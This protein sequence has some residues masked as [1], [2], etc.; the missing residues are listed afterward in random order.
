MPF[1]FSRAHPH[2]LPLSLTLIQPLS[3]LVLFSPKK[4][5]PSLWPAFHIL[6]LGTSGSPPVFLWC[7]LRH[8][9][10]GSEWKGNIISKYPKSRDGHFQCMYIWAVLILSPHLNEHSWLWVQAHNALWP[11]DWHLF[12]EQYCH[13]DGLLCLFNHMPNVLWISFSSSLSDI[14]LPPGSWG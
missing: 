4:N 7:L 3:F 12:A 2:A 11:L 10:Q 5:S 14:L 9:F 8:L 6:M 13:G 1:L